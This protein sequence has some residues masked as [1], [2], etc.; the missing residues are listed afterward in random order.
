LGVKATQ[1][2]IGGSDHLVARLSSELLAL[3][4]LKGEL[5]SAALQ[6]APSLQEVSRQPDAHTAWDWF[7]GLA[8]RFQTPTTPA[9]VRMAYATLTV[10]GGNVLDRLT[11]AGGGYYDQ[12]HVRRLSDKGV[13]GLARTLTETQMFVSVSISHLVS[14][15][16]P[17]GEGRLKMSVVSRYADYVTSS[18]LRVGFSLK[19]VD[20]S[21]GPVEDVGDPVWHEEER[22]RIR[23]HTFEVALPPPHT[24]DHVL[25]FAFEGERFIPEVE[26]V[27]AKSRLDDY[28]LSTSSYR[29]TARVYLR[30]WDAL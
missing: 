7:L 4:G 27:V 2:G 28:L 6:F 11:N 14:V 15:F 1:G 25:D 12:R 26:F 22:T 23:V 21:W 5:D 8:P 30:D 19:L 24:G 13:V 20:G 29:T 10:G 16:A 3:R 9:E 18:P 17:S